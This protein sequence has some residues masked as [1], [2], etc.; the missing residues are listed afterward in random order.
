[1]EFC[2][3]RAFAPLRVG[4][5]VVRAARQGGGGTAGG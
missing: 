4:G 1:M 3:R 5:E 2:R